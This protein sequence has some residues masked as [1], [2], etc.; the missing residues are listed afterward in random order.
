MSAEELE[1]EHPDTDAVPASRPTDDP[2]PRLPAHRTPAEVEAAFAS[3]IASF[4]TDPTAEPNWPAAENLATAAT[5]PA[6][7]P[8]DEDPETE[9]VPQVGLTRWRGSTVDPYGDDDGTLLDALDTF[10]ADLPDEDEDRYVPPPPPPLPHFSINGIL[11][12]LALVVGLVILLAPQL[13]PI[14][15]GTARFFGFVAMVAGAG[16]LIW[17][18]RPG[19]DDDEP[20]SA[21]GAVV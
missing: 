11:G 19:G 16:A 7:E 20:D 9:P 12:T 13:L 10:G 18:L 15:E 3:I 8:E 14:A 4:H 6:A 5:P 2:S 17:R 1:P 21:D